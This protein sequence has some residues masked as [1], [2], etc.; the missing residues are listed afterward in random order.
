MAILSSLLRIAAK[1]E[2]Q[3][4]IQGLAGA[5]GGVSKAGTMASKSLGGLAQAAS[6]QGLGGAFSRLI[7]LLSVGGIVAMA[8]STIDAADALDD[9]SE[10][11][12]VSVEM[13]ARFKKAAALS[14]TSIETVEKGL[15]RLA[16]AMSAAASNSRVSEL[17]KADMDRAVEAVRSGERRQVEAVER[18]ANERLQAV[19]EESGQRMAELN[20]RYRNEERILDDRFDDR[21][22]AEERAAERETNAVEKSIQRR[23]DALRRG[24]QRDERLGE[25]AK[26]QQLQQ[27]QDAEDAQLDAV[28]QGAAEQRRAR[29]R[30]LRDQQQ[31]QQDA[32][33]ERKRREEAALKASMEAQT[34]EIKAGTAAQV[35]AFKAAADAREKAIKGTN[36][37]ELSQQM[38]EL[39]L[40]GKAAS[41]TFRQLGVAVTDASGKLRNPADVML[42]VG[43]A[44]AKIPQEAKRTELAMK[45]LG[46]GGTELIPMFLMGS[47]AIREIAVSMTT[48]FAAAADKYQKQLVDLQ[49]KV[50]K[51]G[52]DLA[53]ILLPA[54]IDITSAVTDAVKAF[55][56]LPG[57]VK[58]STLAF[59]G[60]S[61][62]LVPLVK[63]FQAI[64]W[65]GGAISNLK[66]GATIAGWLG[67]AGPAIITIKG[68][69]A[70]VISWVTTVAFPAV[71]AFFSGPVGWAILAVALVTLLITFRKQIGD[72]LAW[73]LNIFSSAMQAIANAG[74]SIGETIKFVLGEAWKM[75]SNSIKNTTSGAVQ[76]LQNIWQSFVGW[77]GI[78]IIKPVLN[79]WNGFTGAVRGGMKSAADF[80]KGIWD[81]IV[82]N[83]TGAVNAIA[84]AIRSLLR[85]VIDAVNTAIRGFN[86]VS[87]RVSGF[88]VSE[89]PA[90]AQGAVVT[91]P[92]V[93]LLGDG[94]EPEYVVPKS[95]AAGFA[96]RYLQGEGRSAAGGGGSLTAP[97]INIT[98]GPVM[99]DQTGQRWATVDD[100]ERVAVAARD[101]TLALLRN[102][103]AR[104][105]LGIA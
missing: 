100:L 45:L 43:D 53:F 36:A 15:T 87:G 62:V 79:L 14:G 52:V 91:K 25:D 60:L 1:A 5:I 18:A 69:I 102:P 47:K 104:R 64:A 83:I 26:E 99:Q 34:S 54:L 39:G 68:L 70:G 98:T 73:L 7:P 59:V 58:G 31:Q 35:A 50:G 20:R 90:F 80:I 41:E 72:F 71:V 22:S 63:I 101:G 77:F 95:K 88:T 86:S 78:T 75:I 10:R 16:R 92:T 32:I 89:I 33:D 67:A 103:Q 29:E 3:G 65:I 12:G 13:L 24:I 97:S 61:L 17:T 76:F 4:A 51:L 2:G 55:N 23:F 85:P 21:R 57:W 11:T 27:L 93:A 42:D 105:A 37:N 6:M 49:G 40:S 38:E 84:S 74:Y 66:I 96:T 19:Q 46:R 56:A 44:L 48:Q 82:R 28:R 9:M 81:N 8:K 94:G 30:A